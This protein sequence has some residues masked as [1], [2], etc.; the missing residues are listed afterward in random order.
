MEKNRPLI[1]TVRRLEERM[2]LENLLLAVEILEKKYPEK[3]FQLAIVGKGRLKQ[4]LEKMISQK[5]EL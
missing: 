3:F 4:R 1:L 2:G 5:K